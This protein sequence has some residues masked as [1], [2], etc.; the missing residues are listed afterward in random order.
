MCNTT[1]SKSVYDEDTEIESGNEQVHDVEKDAV[2][3]K[4]DIYKKKDQP[5]RKQ[6]C[7][8]DGCTAY[9]FVHWHLE[10]HLRKHTGEVMKRCSL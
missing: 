7:T 2:S 10:R 4:R 8:F 6:Y 1:A 9:F 3:E 5:Y